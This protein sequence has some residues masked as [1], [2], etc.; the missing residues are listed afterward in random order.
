MP[1][2][3]GRHNKG[4]P[5]T[6]KTKPSFA[7]PSARV[8]GSQVSD[9]AR[10]IAELDAE[11]SHLRK[12]ARREVEE[13]WALHH[14]ELFPR[15]L[16]WKES[17]GLAHF[18]VYSHDGK[19]LTPEALLSSPGAPKLHGA[20]D[21]R[22]GRAELEAAWGAQAFDLLAFALASRDLQVDFRTGVLCVPIAF[23]ETVTGVVLARMQVSDPKSYPRLLLET[24]AFLTQV[25]EV[26]GESQVPASV[27]RSA[28]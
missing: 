3:D 15:F 5:R 20:L 27:V 1:H 19:Y 4:A 17:L 13:R 6:T 8:H 23:F 16:Q 21:V 10:H 28:S 9:L 12:A 2:D 26:S 14:T 22:Q 18:A 25:R 7:Q 24:N 11:V